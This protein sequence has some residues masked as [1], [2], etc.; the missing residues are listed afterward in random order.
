MA[1]TP[2]VASAQPAPEVQLGT[3]WGAWIGLVGIALAGAA[4]A[5]E[6]LLSGPWPAGGDPAFPA[7]LEDNR[8]LILAQSMLF[9]LGAAASIWFL[10]CIRAR[11]LRAEGAGG[12]LSGVAFGAGLITYA[13]I[14]IGQAAQITLTLPA[15]APVAPEVAG[16]VEGLCTVITILANIPAAVMFTAVAVVTLTRRAFPPWIGWIAVLCAVTSLLSGLAVVFAEGPLSPVGWLTSIA[17]LV[18][19]LF[20]V[21]VAVLLM[22][23]RG[24]GA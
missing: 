6:P 12:T 18:P 13:M 14:I 7:F 4:G 11:L 16:V 19:V 10:G 2:T 17:R 8:S 9:V 21:P 1:T 5:I 22:R 20:Y 3:V 24:P 15:E 23:R